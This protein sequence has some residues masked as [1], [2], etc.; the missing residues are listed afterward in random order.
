LTCSLPSGWQILPIQNFYHWQ[1]TVNCEVEKLVLIKTKRRLYAQVQDC[2]RAHHT[3]EV[4]EIIQ[5]PITDGLPAYLS[6]IAKECEGSSRVVALPK[7]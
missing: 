3:Y 6:W 7:E 5:V 1:G 2:I 4:P